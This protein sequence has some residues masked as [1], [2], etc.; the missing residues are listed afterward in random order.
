ML[1]S[2]CAP[3]RELLLVTGVTVLEDDRVHETTHKKSTEQLIIMI[4]ASSPLE[5][6]WKNSECCHDNVGPEKG[7]MICLTQNVPQPT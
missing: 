1:A 6:W 2:C 4:K 5:E 7:V 3:A